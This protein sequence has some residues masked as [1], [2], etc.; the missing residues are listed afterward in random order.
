[1]RRVVGCG[2]L[3]C[4]AV[5]WAACARAQKVTLQEPKAPLLPESFG[6]WKQTTSVPIANPPRL[7]LVAVSKAAL[8]ECNPARSKVADYARNGGGAVKTIHVEAI[9]FNDRTGAESAFTLVAKPE[10]KLG[11]ELGDLDATGDGAVLL[12][13]G[14]TL[15]LVTGDP[16]AK[17]LEPLVTVLPKAFGNANVAPLLPTLPPRAGLVAGSVRYALGPQ[18]YAA[19]GGVLPAQS[20]E[21]DKSAEA[22]TATYTGKAGRETLTIA[23]YPTP[24]IA[25]AVTKRVQA[26][27]AAMGPQFATAKARRERI[28]FVLASGP[29]SADDAQKLIDSVH[30]NEQLAVDK[31]SPPPDF[32]TE[33]HKTVS[34]LVAISVFSGALMVAALVLAIFFGGGRAILR[35]LQGKPAAVEAEFL[36]L[37]L[38]PQNA[39]VRTDD[40]A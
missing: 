38:A 13:S 5:G 26:Q 39:P 21:W 28:L 33:V 8:E 7:S 15:V 2:W 17:S 35:V 19:E 31:G 22:L 23:G 34:L 9:E 6:A 18:S 12:R 10:M 40:E 3:L 4:V 20:L 30:L 29:W 25:S 24:E 36:S 14:A 11:K 37:H 32:N 1:M 16:D 27:V